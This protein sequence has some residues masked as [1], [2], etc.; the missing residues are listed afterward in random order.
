[1]QIKNR[2]MQVVIEEKNQGAED[3]TTASKNYLLIG[4]IAYPFFVIGSFVLS[5][6]LVFFLIVLEI[7]I[8]DLSYILPFL[9]LFW[10]IVAFILII[11][12]AYKFF[13]SIKLAL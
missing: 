7:P 13:K 2:L 4:L 10:I 8:E 5:I 9:P 1:M 3:K 11:M 6:L 12:I